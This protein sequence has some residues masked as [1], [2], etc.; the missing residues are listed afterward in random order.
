MVTA[1]NPINLQV[2]R[3]TTDLGFGAVGGAVWD[4]SQISTINSNIAAIQALLTSSNVNLDTVQ[5]IVTYI[6]ANQAAITTLGSNK[7]NVSD[8]INVLTDASTNKPLS[9]AQ[10]TA[11][12]VLLD[13]LTGVVNGKAPA[14]NPTLTGT[15]NADDFIAKRYLDQI[16]VVSISAGVLTL[17]LS[18]AS[19]FVVSLNVD[20]TSVV[21]QNV[22]ASGKAAA[23]SIKFVADGTVRSIA[24]PSSIKWPN[25]TVPTM[26]GTATKVDLISFVSHDG[27]ANWYGF[28]AG[29]NM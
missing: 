28:A 16:S 27:G 9:A 17:D 3:I 24:W 10:G 15:S 8:V 14:A 18:A 13:S 20:I 11:L 25:A 22:Y 4:A 5:E 7:V 2:T 1:P 19:F 23:F 6:E 26:T 21:L 12:K 29:Q